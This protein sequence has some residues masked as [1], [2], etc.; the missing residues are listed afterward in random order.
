[1]VWGQGAVARLG[2]ILKAVLGASW[3]LSTRLPGGRPASAHP[4]LTTLA[5]AQ[6]T[7]PGAGPHCPADS[8]QLQRPRQAAAQ[9]PAPARTWALLN[10][11]E[12]SLV[13]DSD[14]SLSY[15][16]GSGHFEPLP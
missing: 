14:L 11:W 15:S 6:E 16:P 10:E 4:L 13:R 9:P 8:L 12:G 5:P 2:H 7:E 1:M 3:R